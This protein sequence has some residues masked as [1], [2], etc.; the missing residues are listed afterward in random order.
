MAFRT[1]SRPVPTNV[2]FA[3]VHVPA[4]A[5]RTN[6][7]NTSGFAIQ[8]KSLVL[9][10]GSVNVAFCQKPR[11]RSKRKLINVRSAPGISDSLAGKD[12]STDSQ[13]AADS[14]HSTSENP[15]AKLGLGLDPSDILGD[16]SVLK[17]VVREG[18]EPKVYPILGDECVAHFVGTLPDGTIFND[19]YKRDQPFQFS[20]GAEQV[21]EGFDEGVATMCKGERAVFTL[22][23]EMAYGSFGARDEKAWQ[24]PP[25]T[26]V[27]FDI[28][29]I[30]V[31]KAAEQLEG[32][33]ET[34]ARGYGREDVGPGGK[35]ANG[36]CTWE[37]K[38]IEVLVTALV[39]H[40]V[41]SKNIKYRFGEKSVYIAV[42]DNVLLDGIP[43][44]DLN[45]EEC[46]WE[47]ETNSAGQ[48]VLLVHLQK[49]G[50]LTARWPDSL[51]K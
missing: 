6:K 12:D 14:T 38:G 17:H 44:C 48:K 50:S 4:L 18:A 47:L 45:F 33:G 39:G 26:P 9:L 10:S 31:I 1:F 25:D 35:A 8:D 41:T 19:T 49:K 46:Y 5:R 42:K 20:L 22:E 40:D 16:G 28:E 51:L 11:A 24:V 34:T 30:D 2:L 36:K 37:R 23:P 27:T 3:K 7:D 43:G 13:D 21:L 29:L 32:Q 15:F